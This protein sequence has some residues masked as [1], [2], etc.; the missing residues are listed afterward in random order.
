M[1]KRV[2]TEDLDSIIEAVSRFPNGVSIGELVEALDLSVS[3][4]TLQRYL[5]SLIEQNRLLAI[6][7]LRD[8]AEVVVMETFDTA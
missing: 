5:T 8:N 4:R 1:P 2:T 7:G 6:D 3:R